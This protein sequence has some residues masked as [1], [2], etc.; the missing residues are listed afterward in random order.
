MRAR[1]LSWKLVVPFDSTSL[2]LSVS[3]HNCR[4]PENAFAMQKREKKKKEREE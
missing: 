1:R 4:S 2:S 3:E